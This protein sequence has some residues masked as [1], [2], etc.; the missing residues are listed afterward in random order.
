MKHGRGTR[1][2]APASDAATRRGRCCPR[3]PPRRAT[4]IPRVFSRFAPTRLRLVPIRVE[5]GRLWPESA[6][7]A[8]TDDSGRNYK[9]KKKKKEGAK[10]TI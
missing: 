6:V 4:W 1:G 2:A 10:R 3:V 7:S 9:I 5:L 8:E